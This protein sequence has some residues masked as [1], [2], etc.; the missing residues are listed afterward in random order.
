MDVQTLQGHD[1]FDIVRNK[2]V[3]TTKEISKINISFKLKFLKEHGFELS[4]YYD[5]DFRNNIAH[6]NYRIDND[7]NMWIKGKKFEP[8][9]FIQNIHYITGLISDFIEYVLDCILDY[10]KNMKIK[11]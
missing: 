8:L 1:I 11:S 6:H 2:Y 3:K 10:K 7:G 4:K 5:L 9:G